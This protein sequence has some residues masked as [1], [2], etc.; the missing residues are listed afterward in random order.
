MMTDI[1]EGYHSLALGQGNELNLY[2]F[3]ENL[4]DA[5]GYNMASLL[6]PAAAVEE[7]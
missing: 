1:N 6:L 5:I 3:T 7:W 2:R 4:I